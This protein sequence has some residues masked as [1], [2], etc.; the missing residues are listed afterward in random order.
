MKKIIEGKLYNTE[1]A[2]LIAEYRKGNRTDFNGIEEEVY[3]T[4]KGQYFMYFWGGALTEYREEVSHRN[5]SDNED[6][7]LI[8]EK[9]AKKFAMKHLDAEDFIEIFGEVEEG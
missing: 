5:Y 4:K 1:T 6:I 3:K 8:T 9:E 2:T 7:K